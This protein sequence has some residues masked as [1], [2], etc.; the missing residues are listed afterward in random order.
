M[1]V[2]D[3]QYMWYELYGELAK[4]LHDFYQK[5]KNDK[6]KYVGELF[7]D[8]CLTKE[9]EF[10]RLFNWSNNITEKSLDPFHVFASFNN[11]STTMDKK[12]ERLQFYF[13]I[14]E[15]KINA[16]E[17]LQDNRFS[18]PHIAII[19]AV[20]NRDKK[21]Q[22]EIWKFFDAVLLNNSNSIQSGF[23]TSVNWFGIG[24]TLLTEFLFWVDSD[25]YLSLDK[26]TIALLKKYNFPIPKDYQTYNNLLLKITEFTNNQNIFRL[27]IEYAYQQ[28]EFLDK[29][30][31]K[32][33][34]TVLNQKNES[35]NENNEYIEENYV[36]SG[37]VQEAKED[38][39]FQLIAL[40]VLNNCWDKY[41]KRLNKNLYIFSDKFQFSP[42]QETIIYIKK[43]DLNLFEIK[44]ITGT[45]NLKININVIVGKNGS[46]KSTLVELAFMAINNLY[47]ALE[48]EEI[49][50]DQIAPK[51]IEDGLHVE[52][53]FMTDNLYKVTVE[54]K[55]I[56]IEQY[57]QVDIAKDIVTY[58]KKKDVSTQFSIDNLYY[59]IHLNYS[60]HSL[61]EN[62]FGNWLFRLFHKNDG[63]KTPIVLEPYRKDGNIDIN[64]QMSLTQDRLLADLLVMEPDTHD[65]LLTKKLKAKSLSLR[66]NYEKMDKYKEPTVFVM[67]ELRQQ[68]NKKFDLLL[69]DF[70]EDIL[71]KFKK[72]KKVYSLPF[73]NISL[74]EEAKKIYQEFSIEFLTLMYIYNKLLSM[75]K[76]YTYYKQ[77]KN[78]LGL[79]NIE[80]IFEFVVKDISHK[81]FKIKRAI[82]FLKFYNQKFRRRDQT[83]DLKKLSDEVLRIQATNQE[84]GILEFLPPSI[85]TQEIIFDNGQKFDGLS[86]GE[87]Q[88]IFVLTAIT[89]HLT[90]LASSE[91]FENINIVLDEIELYFHPEMQ[92][93]FI[94]D[95]YHNLKENAY[96]RN[97]LRQLNFIFVT[98]SPFILSDVTHHELLALDENAMPKPDL[99]PTFGANIYELL[100]DSFFMESFWGNFAKEKIEEIV[101]IVR[102]YELCKKESRPDEFDE[103]T[104]LY[105]KKYNIKEK[106]EINCFEIK[107]KIE[108]D[109]PNLVLLVESVGEKIIR[110][111]LLQLLD[112][113]GSLDENLAYKLAKHD[114]KLLEEALKLA[115]E[116]QND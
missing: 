39:K 50:N 76:N 83:I 90:N 36:E 29:Q 52:L 95:L 77:F 87:K 63:Y 10:H 1:G 9:F 88:K 66:L 18:V 82:Y 51:L 99:K 110:Y 113:I 21:T 43:N 42:N 7:Y 72:R 46:G 57:Q 44:Q 4:G 12:W 6:E 81:A 97:K 79:H 69:E 19:Y 108:Q 105:R 98:H 93:D 34:F 104:E 3:N 100:Q 2:D 11:S 47:I 91:N 62:Y 86:S 109:K 107:K 112:K 25:K 65:R 38:I 40:R 56:L 106:V 26:N 75:I 78:K 8:L 89:Y 20:S 60:L 27:L 53:F 96:I 54:N 115:Q 22:N 94:N 13:D 71:K 103:F 5:Y 33:L 16:K 80:E 102:L 92:K 55:N 32:S 14:L 101:K 58:G 31:N 41:Y 37:Y 30:S 59:T 74:Y 68:I 111:E 17:A 49:T 85:Y 61:N 70:S 24:F 28:K 67:R 114:V 73:R 64:S 15:I 116:N 35:I 84:L 45:D 23:E 48:K